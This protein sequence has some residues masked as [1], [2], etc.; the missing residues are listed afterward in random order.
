MSAERHKPATPEQRAAALAQA[1]EALAHAKR[2]REPLEAPKEAKRS[3]EPL[4]QPEALREFLDALD[5]A[6]KAL[7]R[8]EAAALDYA[9]HTEGTS[10]NE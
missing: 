1:R 2:Y 7:A 9:P 4:P 6:R 3:P 8:L 10:P 5:A